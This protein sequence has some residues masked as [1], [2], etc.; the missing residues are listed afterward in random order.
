MTVEQ[1]I[2]KIC[3]KLDKKDMTYLVNSFKNYPH[4]IILIIDEIIEG[5]AKTWRWYKISVH[6]HK[7]E[8]S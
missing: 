8:R 4:F 6:H 2:K 3:K 7:L 1:R 5:R